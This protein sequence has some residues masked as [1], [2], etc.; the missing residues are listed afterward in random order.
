M[1]MSVLNGMVAAFVLLLFGLPIVM[2]STG[3][4]TGII[5]ITIESTNQ[6]SVYAS[7]N[8]STINFINTTIPAA[9]QN[10]SSDTAAD[11][12]DS[13]TGFT[14]ENQGNVAVTLD[15]SSNVTATTF[16]GGTASGGPKFQYWAEEP[17]SGNCA[18]L[19]GTKLA[20]IDFAVTDT[21]VCTGT[22]L[23]YESGHDTLQ[24]YIHL[25]VPSDA[26]PGQKSALLTFTST[27]A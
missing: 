13:V 14:V 16:I 4:G 5:G 6:I 7:D 27:S 23:R 21:H 3:S 11:M 26:P 22:G 17:V 2:A 25:Y 1:R 9:G 24:T 20:P 10:F 18:A 19:Q 8:S 15:V 12:K